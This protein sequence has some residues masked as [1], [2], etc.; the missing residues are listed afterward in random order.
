M[1]RTWEVHGM[2]HE[3]ALPKLVIFAVVSTAVPL[4]VVLYEISPED[5][6]FLKLFNNEIFHTSA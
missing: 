3:D 6:V 5:F 1:A 4:I 2:E